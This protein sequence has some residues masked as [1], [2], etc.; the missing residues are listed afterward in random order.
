MNRWTLEPRRTQRSQRDARTWLVYGFVFFVIFAVQ[1]YA[2]AQQP[3]AQQPAAQRTAKAAAVFDPTGYWVPLIT[4]DWRFRMVTPPK[5]DYASVPLTPEGRRVADTWDLAKDDAAGNQC[6]AFGVGGILR[7]PGRLHITWEN[8]DTLKMDFDAGQQSRLLHFDKGQ[9]PAEK[10]WQGYSVA[11]WDVPPAGGRGAPGNA[12]G[13]G[14]GGVAGG[15]GAAAAG[16][17]GGGGGGRGGGGRAGGPPAVQRGA[18]K[19]TTTNFREA[20]FRKNGVPYSEN[21]I[22]TEYVDR[23]GPE[24]DGAIYL[25]VRMTIDD[26]KYLNQPFVTST[27]FRLE[28]D[29]ASKRRPYPCKTD[30]PGEPAK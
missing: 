18:I 27:H 20:Y 30:P 4:E 25:L 6:K 26:P 9:P 24:P 21:A 23:L 1:E 19:I 3:A 8:D 12:V 5:G 17:G 7:Q 13:A 29:G 15:G 10:T 16:G 22:I 2:A 28:P 11:E 14:G